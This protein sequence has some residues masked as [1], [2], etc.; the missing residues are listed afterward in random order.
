MGTDG[1]QSVDT[2]LVIAIQELKRHYIYYVLKYLPTKLFFDNYA[3][4]FIIF[5]KVKFP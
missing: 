1:F 5:G 3:K 2:G 4:Y